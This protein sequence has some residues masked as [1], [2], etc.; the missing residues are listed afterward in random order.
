MGADMK[1]LLLGL[2][3]LVSALAAHAGVKI[4]HWT[5]P[6][7]ARVYFVESR[8]LPIVDIQVDFSAGAAYDPR[9]KSGVSG[10]TRGL[11]EAGAGDMDEE[12]IAGRLVD[13]G[14]RL[15]GSADLDRAGLSLR[16]LSSL[17]ERDAAVDLMRTLLQQPTF[18]AEVLAREKARTIAGIRESDTRPASMAAKRFS[19]ALYPDHPYGANASVESV[20]RITRDDLAAFHRAH[21]GARRAVVSIIG[22]MSRAEAE[23]IAVRLTDGLPQAQPDDGIPEVKLPVRATVRIAHPA[24][25]AHI[26]LG[27]PGMRRGDPDYFPLLVGNYT[28][29]GG[30]FVSRLMKEVREKRGY[31]YSVYSYFQPMRQ[32]G[33]FQV[34]LQTKREQAGA[35]LA[36]VEATLDEFVK[37]GPTQEEVK[38]A[39]RNLVDGFALR[40]DSNRK[41]LEYLAV[42][43]FYGLP[44]TYLDDFP[45]QVEAV[46]ATQI[47]DAFQRKVKAEHIV[48]VIVAGE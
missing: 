20:T 23:A 4:Q 40:L 33:P 31:A 8:E 46:T 42:I 43:G 45:R 28:L 12:R 39:K 15:S 41:I 30:G 21:Y 14:A 1:K 2:A 25:Q 27:L 35:A 16:T 18:P 13:I 17:R 37:Q 26:Y 7:G 29:G 9:D 11:L 3:L 44:L 10:L 5:A 36:V 32:A 6:S 24:S 22:D 38:A 47:R 48:T 19:A 34:G